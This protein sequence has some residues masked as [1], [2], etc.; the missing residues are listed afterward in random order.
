MKKGVQV[1]LQ[2][3]SGGE[4]EGERAVRVSVLAKSE[5]ATPSRLCTHSLLRP[6]GRAPDEAAVF[7]GQ[8]WPVRYTAWHHLSSGADDE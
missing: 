7:D 1:R 4:D 5:I 2:H 3:S 8:R 6:R